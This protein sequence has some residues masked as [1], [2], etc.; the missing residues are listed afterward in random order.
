MAPTRKINLIGH[1]EGFQQTPPNL[2]PENIMGN[3]RDKSVHVYVK[4]L[5]LNQIKSDN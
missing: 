1:W 5:T 3:T 2:G 4:N